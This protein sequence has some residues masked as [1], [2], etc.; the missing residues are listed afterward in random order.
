[1]LFLIIGCRS[2]RRHRKDFG[3]LTFRS[4]GAG[5][6]SEWVLMVD[7][8]DL[9]ARMGGRACFC[10]AWQRLDLGGGSASS[11]EACVAAPGG[12]IYAAS[13]GGHMRST[14]RIPKLPMRD[15]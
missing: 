2:G 15:E 5:C 6:V 8:A 14:L 12:A 10:R 3:N 13:V 9:E 1:M 11:E 4:R 7:S